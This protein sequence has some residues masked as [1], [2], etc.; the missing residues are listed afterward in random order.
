MSPLDRIDEPACAQLRAVRALILAIAAE[1]PGAGAVVE[2]VKW[3]QASFTTRPRTGTPIRLGLTRAGL[4]ALFVHCQTR[5]VADFLAGPG[6]DLSV[7][8]TRAV[9]LPENPALLTP[10]IRAALTY[11]T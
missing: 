2:E 5:L 8:G 7:E 11:H 3:G 4:P 10:L 1:T 6:R 9:I